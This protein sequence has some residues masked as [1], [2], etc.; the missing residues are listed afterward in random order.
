MKNTILKK[1][2][3]NLIIVDWLSGA[4]SIYNQAAGNTEIVGVKLAKLLEF[5]V[6]NREAHP[7]SFHLIGFS[8]GAHVAGHCGKAMRESGFSIGSITGKSVDSIFRTL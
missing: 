4:K 3:V 8:L 2:D 5:L 1:E 7:E 6:T